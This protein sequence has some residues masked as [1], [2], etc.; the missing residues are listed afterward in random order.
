MIVGVGV[1]GQVVCHEVDL[2]P[3]RVH[4]HQLLHNDPLRGDGAFTAA[5]GVIVPVQPGQTVPFRLPEA[6][7]PVPGDK[8]GEPVVSESIQSAAGAHI[9]ELLMGFLHQGADFAGLS[10]TQA[11]P[12]FLVAAAE[13]GEVHRAAVLQP[14]GIAGR[15]I[16]QQQ[17]EAV[18]LAVQLP[19]G[20]VHCVAQPEGD[21][22]E[23]P[24]AVLGEGAAIAAQ[25]GTDALRVRVIKG[26]DGIELLHRAHID[27]E[28]EELPAV[29]AP[30]CQRMLYIAGAL[31]GD[32]GIIVHQMAIVAVLH[33]VPGQAYFFTG[34]TAAEPE[35]MSPEE[36]R[37]LLIRRGCFLG[38]RGRQTDNAVI[39]EAP[40]AV[41]TLMAEL[42]A[43]IAE[44]AVREGKDTALQPQ[45]GAELGGIKERGSA[46][47]PG[48]GY[49]FP[50][51]SAIRQT[52]F[53]GKVENPCRGAA[54]HRFAIEHQAFHLSGQ[55]A[56]SV[57]IAGFDILH[58]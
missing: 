54:D 36:E 22:G 40:D 15:G 29:R 11:E 32:G 13:P 6:P 3:L 41:R 58:Q 27:L 49:E 25:P 14:A 53:P 8:V 56:G 9:E 37:R 23:F 35:V 50:C 28:G 21:N 7:L 43:G 33:A 31:H 26:L 42:Q 48:Q 18:G 17:R 44:F 12:G 55:E 46:A 52:V 45:Q 57:F 24:V 20:A 16:A 10:V 47:V 38:Q 51:H 2:L 5:I 34:G 4:C 30:D 39:R 19:Q 1:F